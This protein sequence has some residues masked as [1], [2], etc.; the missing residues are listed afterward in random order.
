MGSRD[1]DTA[2]RYLKV[3][4]TKKQICMQSCCDMCSCLELENTIM[5]YFLSQC[6]IAEMQLAS[7]PTQNKKEVLFFEIQGK[8]VVVEIF[9]LCLLMHL[10]KKAS[11]V[12]SLRRCNLSQISSCWLDC[13]WLM[14]WD[15]NFP[16]SGWLSH[17]KNKRF[18]L[19]RTL[20]RLC[21]SYDIRDNKYDTG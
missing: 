2:C 7:E 6:C 11:C 1:C 10:S 15:H 14:N 8:S 3:K 12:R 9:G 16:S 18:L 4:S 21:T 20:C 13:V 5:S 17:E 19:N